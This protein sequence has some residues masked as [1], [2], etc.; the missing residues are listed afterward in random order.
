MVDEIPEYLTA[1]EATTL[2][3]QLA[4]QISNQISEEILT[5]DFVVAKTFI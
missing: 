5:H 2:K 3:E 4:S 1:E